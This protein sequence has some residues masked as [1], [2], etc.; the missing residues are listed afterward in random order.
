[1]RK[2]TKLYNFYAVDFAESKFVFAVS[3]QQYLMS[4]VSHGVWEVD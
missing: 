3:E 1:M 2:A 4:I